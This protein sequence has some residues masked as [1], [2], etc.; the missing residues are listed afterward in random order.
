MTSGSP[1]TETVPVS[2][3][4]RDLIVRSTEL[5][6]APGGP[7][8]RIVLLWDSSRVRFSTRPRPR[9]GFQIVRFD[10]VM[11]GGMVGVGGVACCFRRHCLSSVDE[12]WNRPEMEE[13]SVYII[14]LLIKYNT[15]FSQYR[16]LYTSV[17][18]LAK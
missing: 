12:S 2:G 16:S 15:P 9:T 8:I 17:Y 18:K 10:N 7:W 1:V 4:H 13:R 5:L 6:P 14:W 3:F 11:E